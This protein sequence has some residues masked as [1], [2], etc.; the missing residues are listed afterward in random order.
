MQMHARAGMLLE[1]RDGPCE[2]PTVGHALCQ[3][4]RAISHG[5]WKECVAFRLSN[6]GEGSNCSIRAK[7]NERSTTFCL[8]RLRGPICLSFS[9]RIDVSSASSLTMD[10]DG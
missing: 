9:N 6:V 10:G 2:Y 4:S 3:V 7:A 8:E 5:A 1:G